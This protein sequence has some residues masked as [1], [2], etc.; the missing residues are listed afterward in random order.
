VD[1]KGTI[2][3]ATSNKFG[4][5]GTSNTAI[6]FKGD[7]STSYGT[8]IAA[9]DNTVTNT[10][11]I[12]SPGTAIKAEAG[13]TKV[14]NDTGGLISGDNYAILTAA[15]NDVIT[16]KAGTLTGKVDLGTGANV[17]NVSGASGNATL[18]FTINRDTATS[19][20][21]ANAGTATVADNTTIAVNMAAGSKN[22]QNNES[23]LIVEATALTADASKITVQN[24]A[25]LPMVTF[26]AQ[27]TGANLYYIAT[28][29]TNYYTQHSK[30]SS[31]GGALDALAES[32]G[33]DMSVVIGYLD[34]SGNAANAQ[35][36]GPFATN[37]VVNATFSSTQNFNRILSSQ[38]NQMPSGIRDDWWLLATLFDIIRDE[39]AE[40]SFTGYSSNGPGMAFEM[41]RGI[42]EEA[43]L[44]IAASYMRNNI[45]LYDNAGSVG[46]NCLRLGPCVRWQRDGFYA[47]SAATYGFYPVFDN[48]RKISVGSLQRMAE[49]GY[50]M[51]G[52]SPYLEAGYKLPSVKK[53]EITPSASLEY[54]WL[55]STGYT[56]ERAASANLDVDLLKANSLVF[57]LGLKVGKEFEAGSFKARGEFSAGW[58]HDCLS[59]AHDVRASFLGYPEDSFVTKI[60]TFDRNSLRLGAGLN[61]LFKK[62]KALLFNYNGE[63]YDSG[64]GHTFSIASQV[65]F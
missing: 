22:I 12:S 8:P 45:T 50:Y 61:I 63:I 48:K 11:T 57:L 3:G 31:L 1:N 30:D 65:Y 15:G 6:L 43:T 35:H 10:G 13:D 41:Y 40:N 62:N 46:V 47:N 44:A 55:Y 7:T 2:S 36:L 20:Q 37:A 33:G 51:H 53:I 49:S 56:E 9:G 64:A 27:K 38:M 25:A 29:D 28:R 24:D 26:T 5:S 14:T 60:N 52:L 54:D 21:V 58:Q 34:R 23:F 16:I 42:T 19:A 18:N 39:G 17:F 32:A 59:R 4:I